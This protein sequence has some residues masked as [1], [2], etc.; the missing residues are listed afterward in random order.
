MRRDCV[1]AP[2]TDRCLNWSIQIVAERNIYPFDFFLLNF[3]L[4]GEMYM[5]MYMHAY[6]DVE[7]LEIL[8]SNFDFLI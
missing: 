2:S 5:Y 1:N 7:V 6:K 8:S 3:I 4:F